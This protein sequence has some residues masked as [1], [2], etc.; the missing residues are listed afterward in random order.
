MYIRYF[1]VKTPV[2]K[3]AYSPPDMTFANKNDAENADLFTI[4]QPSTV[5]VPRKVFGEEV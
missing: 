5:H 4:P 2:M 3:Q 1:P